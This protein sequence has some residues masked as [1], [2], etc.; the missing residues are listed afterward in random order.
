MPIRS[1]RKVKCLELEP[2]ETKEVEFTLFARD[3]AI[4]DEKGKC[5]IEP[6]KFKISIGGQQPDD[7]SK[8]QS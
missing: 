3:F 5:I 8:E 2:G 1:L 4:I 6:G 7:R